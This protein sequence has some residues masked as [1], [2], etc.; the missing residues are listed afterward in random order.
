MSLLPGDDLPNTPENLLELWRETR[1]NESSVGNVN[2]DTDLGL[3]SIFE[4]ISSQVEELFS[5][6]SVLS[7][8]NSAAPTGSNGSGLYSDKNIPNPEQE[9]PIRKKQES[10]SSLMG[11]G[12]ELANDLLSWQKNMSNVNGS[13]ILDKPWD[14]FFSQFTDLFGYSFFLVP[15]GFIALAL[16]LKTKNVTAVSVWLMGSCFLMGTGIFSSYPEMGFVYYLFAVLGLVGVIV[17][18]YLEGR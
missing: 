6:E 3:G 7:D 10:M 14:T 13:E 16:Y 4:T 15:I 12:K 2:S 1:S 11:F 17:S 9:N 5:E 8:S 18:I